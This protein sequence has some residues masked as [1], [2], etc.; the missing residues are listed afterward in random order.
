MGLL[1]R[2][3]SYSEGGTSGQCVELANLGPG[4]GVR[5]STDPD[6]PRLSVRRAALAALVRELKAGKH[7][8]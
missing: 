8:M 3:S 6:G 7:E 5:D 4:I 1:W 2:K